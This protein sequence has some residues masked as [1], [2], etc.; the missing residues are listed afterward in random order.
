MRVMRISTSNMVSLADPDNL[1]QIPRSNLFRAIISPTFSH[2]RQRSGLG[3]LDRRTLQFSFVVPLF[4]ASN[5]ISNIIP[6]KFL[7]DP[8]SAD[9]HLPQIQHNISKFAVWLRRKWKCIPRYLSLYQFTLCFF[10]DR[11]GCQVPI[12]AWIAPLE[13]ST[14][15]HKLNLAKGFLKPRVGALFPCSLSHPR[16][17]LKIASCNSGRSTRP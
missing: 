8:T 9:G 7:C 15:F 4:G 16:F 6:G 13:I 11:P 17:W 3:L 10:V 14:Y 1:A 5:Y 2:L 12:S